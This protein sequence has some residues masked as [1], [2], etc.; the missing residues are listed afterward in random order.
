MDGNSNRVAAAAAATTARTTSND[1]LPGILNCHM[2][3]HRVEVLHFAN[4]FS[5][6]DS[7]RR[8]MCDAVFQ[9]DALMGKCK[10]RKGVWGPASKGVPSLGIVSTNSRP[11]DE[12]VN[13]FPTVL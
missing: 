11:L 9:L 3:K 2:T 8:R 13:V 1:E 5:E 12:L 4:E 7:E 6:R 10:K